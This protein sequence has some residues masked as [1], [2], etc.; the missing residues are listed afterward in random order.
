MTAA[1]SM[2]INLG[3]MW[4]HDCS[5]TLE[6]AWNVI[7]ANGCTEQSFSRLGLPGCPELL[8]T[9]P[10]VNP[11]V[12]R[13]SSLSAAFHQRILKNVPFS[14]T[15]T[16]LSRLFSAGVSADYK[17]CR[18]C[19]E[20]AVHSAAFDVPWVS[21]CPVH[22]CLLQPVGDYTISR[23]ASRR[24]DR[25]QLTGEL[26]HWANAIISTL[27]QVSRDVHPRIPM[28]RRVTGL[29]RWH[30]EALQLLFNDHL[31]QSPLP[32]LTLG[33]IDLVPFDVYSH[34]V[35][36]VSEAYKKLE[37]HYKF[38]SQWVDDQVQWAWHKLSKPASCQHVRR[39]EFALQKG[40]ESF[41]GRDRIP[42][43]AWE[44]AELT[45]REWPN[46][47]SPRIR[48]FLSTEID[49]HVT[50]SVAVN[51]LP[52]EC[53]RSLVRHKLYQTLLN[54][55]LKHQQRHSIN[56]FGQATHQAFVSE[57][58]DST[59]SVLYISNPRRVLLVPSL[60]FPEVIE[61]ARNPTGFWSDDNW[62]WPW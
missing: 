2:K 45:E 48:A 30:F 13:R 1:S 12:R 24:S 8:L 32:T 37:D 55:L 36:S 21:Q 31:A 7:R 9:P 62:E 14:S 4:D 51:Q 54:H 18:V 23:A 44:V 17:G 22:G 3:R 6:L 34:R 26:D 61:Q 28:S 43:N 57:C 59:L 15:L 38:Q 16:K 60:S 39:G 41:L 58:E 49:Y 19:T 35:C 11:K 50:E 47:R 46:W 20:H 52:T 27:H 56:C 40:L 25:L 53:I 5:S 10:I 33:G 42:K 29:R